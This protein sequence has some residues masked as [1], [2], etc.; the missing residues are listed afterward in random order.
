LGV[1]AAD[2]VCDR[3]VHAVDLRG[4][5]ERD[6]PGTYSIELLTGDVLAVLDAADLPGSVDLV[7]HSLGGLVACRVGVANPRVHR[8]VLE[9]VGLM[10]PRSPSMPARPERE[11]D[12]D[13][14]MVTQVRPVVDTPAGNWPEVFAA[15]RRP[16]LATAD[17][18]QA[19]SRWSGS[20]TSS[21]LCRM[22]RW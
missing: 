7:G 20:R 15:V 12:V 14:R 5:G 16:V 17:G 3:T 22:P 2:L 4:H 6:W 10:R 13:W 1:S 9:D 19:S 8:L 18:R 21:P 11:L